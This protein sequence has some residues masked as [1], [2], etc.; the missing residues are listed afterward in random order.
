MPRPIIHE[1]FWG[2]HTM[3]RPSLVVATLLVAAADAMVGHGPAARVG[4]GPSASAWQTGRSPSMARRGATATARKEPAL[5]GNFEHAIQL[6]INEQS[7]GTYRAFT[8]TTATA[9][10]EMACDDLV[11]GGVSAEP[12]PERQKAPPLAQILLPPFRLGV[13][14][15]KVGTYSAL[16]ATMA[17][18]DAAVAC[19]ANTA[20]SVSADR[21]GLAH[22]E[23][24]H[25][26][27][28][29]QLAATAG[30]VLACG[31]VY[32]R[33]SKARARTQRARANWAR[34]QAAAR[35]SAVK[36][37]AQRAAIIIQA[38]AR[39]RLEWLLV[40]GAA[41]RLQAVARGILVRS[42]L[43]VVCATC[44]I[45]HAVR[46][47]LKHRITSLL[48]APREALGRY[49][50][51]RS[52]FPYNIQARP[53]AAT[54]DAGAAGSTQG[55]TKKKASSAKKARARKD[56]AQRAE[57]TSARNRLL[58]FHAQRR[59]F[60][61][62]PEPEENWFYDADAAALGGLGLS[63]NKELVWP[64]WVGRYCGL[65]GPPTQFLMCGNTVDDDQL[66]SDSALYDVEDHIRACCLDFAEAEIVQIVFP[67]AGPLLYLCYI[68]FAQVEGAARAI[69]WFH[70]I[71]DNV[72]VCFFPGMPK[73]DAAN[74][75]GESPC[76]HDKT[77]AGA[78]PT[79]LADHA[80][81]SLVGSVASRG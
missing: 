32:W 63:A 67:R 43:Y 81:P 54:D 3:G 23:V 14:E 10:V 18:A 49:S 15:R 33:S 61:V 79:D 72:E 7:G 27:Q 8:T 52:G 21:A 36:S 17:T 76:A 71:I 48:Y 37:E 25:D 57:A 4:H 47:F 42:A 29:W 12:Q 66:A 55:A 73:L 51:V 11:A 46:A 60:G 50:L 68:E 64:A 9:S 80:P 44:T 59:A 20:G 34:M 40:H 16:P 1:T 13:D 22:Q 53:T 58:P 5:A 74:G 19:G 75:I 65:S 70:E 69:M 26:L 56:R 2:G 39:Y 77:R 38:G 41:T 28:L 45:Q 31:T 24:W 35:R 78:I 62:D 30:T 6:Q